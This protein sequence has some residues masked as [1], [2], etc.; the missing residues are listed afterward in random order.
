VKRTTWIAAA[1]LL[2]ATI[3]PAATAW[4]QAYSDE[5]PGADRAETA[6]RPGA[7]GVFSPATVGT[8]SS[9]DEATAGGMYTMQG[10]AS[11][12]AGP[13][14]PLVYRVGP[15]DVMLLQ[16]W[17]KL[18]RSIPIEVGPEG[19]V[20]VPGGAVLRVAG[21]TLAD[22]RTDV[23]QRMARQYRDVSMDLRLASPRTFRLYLTGQVRQPGPMMAS[24]ALRVGDVVGR[25]QLLGDASR[26]RIE[27]RH[28]DGTREPC[29][30]D[31][32]LLT[33]DASQN[34]WVRDGDIIQVPTATEFVWAQGA[35]ARPGRF[36][37]GV[38]DSLLDL[39]HLAGDPLP[40]A[41][42]ER[43]LLVRFRDPFVP[44]SAWVDLREVYSRVNN[45]PVVDGERLY[46]YYLPEYH[47]LHE[48]AIMGE[49][50]RPGVYP[51]REG[52]ERISH[53]VTAAGGFRP[54]AD[55]SAIRVHRRSPAA[56]DKDL[57]LDRMLR[58]SRKDLTA[59]EY[60]VM[61]TKLAS[62]GESF[63]VD[64]SRL[65]ADANLDLMLLDG[66]SVFVER[67][68][69]SI[70]VDGQVHRP[71]MLSYAT[72]RG[73]RDYV[74]EA[75]GFT[76]RAWTGKVR[77]T[78]AVTGQ[79]MLAR[80]VSTLDP[81]DFIWVPEKPDITAWEQSR[82]ILTALAQVATIVIA[83]KSVK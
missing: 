50:Q 65:T 68:V 59:T 6:R 8:I 7:I 2:A 28:T 10:R 75:G 62:M 77:V 70:R 81:G 1:L 47:L 80:D 55:L 54:T 48:A 66:D 14:D 32:F 23:L 38:H 74:K 78:R 52:R 60:E 26:R 53:L 61:R 39:L 40:A 19:T 37:A 12:L 43:A 11:S 33:G 34:P 46:V 72:G 20:L 29:D 18:T 9:P 36:E 42:V 13:V 67:L 64:W 4:A 35:L 45:P 83:I 69:P 57:D 58:L 56:N 31:L 73:V 25:A 82:E 16:M 22:V 27:L 44:D 71:G 21:R 17:G 63:R 15:G 51:I 3:V 41:Q 24:G 49:V 79:T 30:L 76:N 5:D